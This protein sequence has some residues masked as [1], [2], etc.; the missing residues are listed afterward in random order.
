M[1]D[2]MNAQIESAAS[3]EREHLEEKLAAME[4]RRSTGRNEGSHPR[5]HH[6]HTHRESQPPRR[7]HR[8]GWPSLHPLSIKA[9]RARAAAEVTREVEAERE[10]QQRTISLLEE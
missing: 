9:D 3:E 4:V 1:R 10:A 7:R 5:L 2:E 6:T 8:P